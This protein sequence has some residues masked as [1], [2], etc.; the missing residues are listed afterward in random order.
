MFSP[1][2]G[3]ELGYTPVSAGVLLPLCLSYSLASEINPPS[4]STA[5]SSASS[6]FWLDSEP[7]LT[8]QLSQTSSLYKVS[9][10]RGGPSSL[11]AC[12]GE[13]TAESL[14]SNKLLSTIHIEGH[15]EN[16]DSSSYKI[17]RNILFLL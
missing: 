3:R 15:L 6:P 1:R 2:G 8:T 14:I 7:N 5:A 16:G 12:G 9:T 4:K 10:R 11:T 17:R 13:K